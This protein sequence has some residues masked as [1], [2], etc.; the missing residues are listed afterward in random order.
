M[1]D[2]QNSQNTHVVHGSSAA[3]KPEKTPLVIGQGIVIRGEII[4]ETNDPESRM[5]ILGT[6]EG[7]IHTK[8]IIQIAKGALVRAGSIIEAGEVVVSGRLVGEGVTVRTDVLVLQSTGYVEVDNVVVPPGGLEQSRGGVLIARLDMSGEARDLS[9]VSS[10]FPEKTVALVAPSAPSKLSF[11]HAAPIAGVTNL[12][13]FS[14]QPSAFNGHVTLPSDDETVG[15]D[16]APTVTKV[17]AVK[18]G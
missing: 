14:S 5:M 10:S 1:T 18:V 15:P 13:T 8:G 9:G 6:I 2:S 7:N 4:D 12:P 16:D 17:D 3:I 11:L